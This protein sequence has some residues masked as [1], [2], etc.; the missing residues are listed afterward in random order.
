MNRGIS[1]ILVAVGAGAISAGLLVSGALSIPSDAGSITNEHGAPES[2]MPVDVRAV[3]SDMEKRYDALG[4][5]Y[6]YIDESFVDSD[7][8]CDFCFGI[9]YD[10]G[11]HK[12]ALVA[13]RSSE[14]I[15]LAEAGTLMFDARGEEGGETITVY[16]AGRRTS[17]ESDSNPGAEGVVNLQFA[18]SKQITLEREWKEYQL[19]LEGLNLAEIT[20]GFAFAVHKGS[21][22]S[23]IVYFD[24]IYYDV[25]RS[26]YAINL[27]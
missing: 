7:N 11:P 10:L 20:H 24:N 2:H 19:N 12:K 4:P 16:V 13:F 1:L 18:F 22:D 8:N 21:S 15:D 17:N 6:V 26:E 9:K 3:F 14:P 23:Q 27:N 5:N 25:K